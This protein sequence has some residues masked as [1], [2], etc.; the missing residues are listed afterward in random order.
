MKVNK[1]MRAL[2]ITAALAVMIPLSTYAATASNS[3]AAPTG[4]ASD[5][6]STSSKDGKLSFHKGKAL[7][8]KEKAGHVHA[9]FR[10]GF[11]S[12]EILD[13][14]KLD[15]KTLQEKL[16]AGK[17]LAQ[18]AEEQ[19]VSRDALKQAMIAAFE[20]RQAEEK[21]EFTDNL[22]K[23]VDGQLK[24]E[25]GKGFGGGF[26][27]KGRMGFVKMDLNASAALLGLSESDLQKELAAGKSLADVAKEKGV[28][29]QKLIDAQKKQIVDGV[30]AAVKAGKMTQKQADKV[31]ADADNIAENTVNGKRFMKPHGPREVIGGT[32]ADNGSTDALVT[33]ETNGA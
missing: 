13:L 27:G 2:T 19:G 22:D 18:V 4:S 32:S 8:D 9:G 23:A 14:L 6:A 33:G 29:V 1:T 7:A 20:K 11:V 26:E 16:A 28:D 3:T 31:I 5:S 10:G 15:K 17:T 25:Q 12:Q 30:N 24:P 21:K